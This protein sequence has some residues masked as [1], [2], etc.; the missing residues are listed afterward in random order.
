MATNNKTNTTHTTNNTMFM[1][2]DRSAA[3]IFGQKNQSLYIN[4]PKF[5]FQYY[6][7]FTLNNTVSA[8]TFVD[9]FFDRGDISIINPLVKSVEMPNIKI[10]TSPLNQYNRK[11]I[12]QSKIAFEPVKI[13]MHDVHDGKT[14]KF[15]DMYYRYYFADGIEPGVN[16]LKNAQT[17]DTPTNV[18]G[19]TLSPTNTNGTKSMLQNILSDKL[20][21]QNF[22]FN[23]PNVQNVRNLIEKI[24]IY[25]VH[26]GKFNQV[27]L[28]NPRISVFSHDTM[29]YAVGDR[30]V[31]ITLTF[32]Y[33]Y[34]YYTTQNALL[35]TNGSSINMFKHAN[36][37]ELSN[38][39]FTQAN[40]NQISTTYRG[41]SVY[42]DPTRTPV[43]TGVAGN[44]NGSVYNDPTRT[45]VTTGVAGNMNGNV[46]GSFNAF[47]NAQLGLGLVNG[48]FKTYGSANAGANLSVS[49][50]AGMIGVSPLQGVASAFGNISVRAFASAASGHPSSAGL[51]VAGGIGGA[52]SA[53]ISSTITGGV[54]SLVQGAGI[55]ST[56]GVIGNV[57]GSASLNANIGASVSA[58]IS[59]GIRGG[60]SG[61]V[62]SLKGSITGGVSLSAAISAATHGSLST[63]SLG[64]G[65]V[66]GTSG[67]SN[68]V[69]VSSNDTSPATSVEFLTDGTDPT[70]TGSISSDTSNTIDAGTMYTDV[71]RSGDF[72]GSIS[73]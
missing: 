29:D 40:I 12:S 25:H 35:G 18:V 63:S 43:T 53:G 73:I 15:W 6:V 58:A 49:A 70:S 68:E 32:E 42:N 41:G 17:Q 3:Y 30:T 65:G 11:R 13:V 31:V 64:G 7:N 2:D 5:P 37:I 22:G 16:Q 51:A 56:T 1:R 72:S 36:T 20:D 55:T 9:T 33:E 60:T 67:A 57:L 69:A 38:T 39:S 62:S 26:A 61:F 47:A 44:M 27:T 48:K 4:Q 28:V 46:N 54:S 34:A 19:T 8:K 21:N 59:G 66:F 45:P 10:E 24:D 23:L 71:D 52:V 14:I 50:I